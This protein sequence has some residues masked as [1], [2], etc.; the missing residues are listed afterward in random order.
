[1][2]IFHDLRLRLASAE[3]FLDA[4][5]PVRDVDGIFDEMCDS[6]NYDFQSRRWAS[7]PEAPTDVEGVDYQPFTTLVSRIQ[8]TALR[9]LSSSAISEDS[10]VTGVWL[11]RNTVTPRSS[12]PYTPATRPEIIFSVSSN[13]IEKLDE[14]ID[15]MTTGNDADRL[16]EDKWFED[17][18]VRRRVSFTTRHI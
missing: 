13:D 5:F 12:H 6:N 3:I 15:A 1:M 8:S 9:T 4:L 17:K 18:L 2:A 7:L 14:Q 11:D 10:P 16:D